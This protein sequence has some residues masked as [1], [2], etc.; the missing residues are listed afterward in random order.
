MGDEHPGARGSWDPSPGL[1]GFGDCAPLLASCAQPT[2]LCRERGLGL[3][4][5]GLGGDGGLWAEVWG[6]EGLEGVE[7]E[8][9]RGGHRMQGPMDPTLKTCLG[10]HSPCAPTS[11]G[12]LLFLNVAP[13]LG[14]QALPLPSTSRALAL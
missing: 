12:R 14:M 13:P 5:P 1:L 8:L 4:T 7:A 10:C 9:T 11:P 6:G 3:G 2:D